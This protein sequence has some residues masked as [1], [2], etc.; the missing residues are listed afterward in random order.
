[1]RPRRSS[2]AGKPSHRSALPRCAD[3]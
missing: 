3:A 2:I 1:M